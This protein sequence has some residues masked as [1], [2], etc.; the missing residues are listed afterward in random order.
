MTYIC[1]LGMN[2]IKYIN[3]QKRKFINILSL[4]ECLKNNKY[5][6]QKGPIPLAFMLQ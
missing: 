3:R 5:V 1:I 4:E 2:W 6:V